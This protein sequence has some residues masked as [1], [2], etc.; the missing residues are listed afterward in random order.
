MLMG[1]VR[2]EVALISCSFQHWL[3]LNF[4]NIFTDTLCSQITHWQTC[5]LLHKSSNSFPLSTMWYNQ[6]VSLLSIYFWARATRH[7][8]FFSWR[9]AHQSNRSPVL[10]SLHSQSSP[11][12]LSGGIPA[13]EYNCLRWEN[14][15][16]DI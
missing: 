9:I 10:N 7:I 2:K 13:E 5:Y 15:I 8:I 4:T 16:K 1:A 11:R 6:V 14:P 12:E 3:L